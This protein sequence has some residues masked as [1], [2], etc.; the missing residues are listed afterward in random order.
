MSKY[1]QRVRLGHIKRLALVT[2]G[3]RSLEQVKE[4]EQPDL[5]CN[6]GF[7]DSINHP[8]HHLKADGV[9]RAKAAWGCW[10]Y[11]WDSGGDIRL[12]ALPAGER[13]SYIGGYSYFF[14]CNVEDTERD[15][16]NVNLRKAISYAID[17]QQVI[18][19][20]FKNDN[21]PSQSFA[22]GIN[23]VNTETFSEVVV[24]ANGGE[25]LYPATANEE[26]AKEYL[27]SEEHTSELHSR[28]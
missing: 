11:A 2:G 26:L 12:C 14:Y 28:I 6:A 3:G 25:P 1:I 20:V 5:I 17:R 7:F 23:G 24:A 22:F 4:T 19:T 8:T 16:S 18:D 13:A 21:K 9:V 15:I 27:R 10:G